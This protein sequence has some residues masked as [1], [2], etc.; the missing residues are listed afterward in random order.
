MGMS[1]IRI[2]GPPCTHTEHACVCLGPGLA[3][4]GGGLRY[5][6]PV[7]STYLSLSHSRKK[8]NLYKKEKTK[9]SF[10]LQYF[11]TEDVQMSDK[12]VFRLH[13]FYS[14]IP[15]E[16]LCCMDLLSPQKQRYTSALKR[17]RVSFYYAP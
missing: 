16:T 6:D 13:R 10:I 17:T 1:Y 2:P 7:G 14:H 8:K 3:K 5:E 9:S 15:L 11:P 4:A 12:N